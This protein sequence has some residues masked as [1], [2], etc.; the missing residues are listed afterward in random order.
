M[1]PYAPLPK[2]ATQAQ[3]IAHGIAHLERFPCPG[4]QDVVTLLRE[5]AEAK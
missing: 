3:R 1:S 4:C 5:I 2:G